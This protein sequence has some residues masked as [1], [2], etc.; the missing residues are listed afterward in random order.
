M[1]NSHKRLRNRLN[2]CR[3][4]MAPTQTRGTVT[5]VYHSHVGPNLQ[6]RSNGRQ[7]AAEQHSPHRAD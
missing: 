4:E 2:N 1:A 7:Q 5:N 6:S 3:A